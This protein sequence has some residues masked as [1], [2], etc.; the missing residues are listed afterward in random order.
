MRNSTGEAEL[1]R[2][3]CAWP[4]AVK[5]LLETVRTRAALVQEGAPA[6]L[7]AVVVLLLW[8]R[9]ARTCVI[10]GTHLLST[11]GRL[12]PT[13]LSNINTIRTPG[14]CSVSRL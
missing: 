5:T 14:S 2:P 4:A 12:S 10:M 8:Y 7:V 1:I 13:S 3:Y 11:T 9:I 6:T